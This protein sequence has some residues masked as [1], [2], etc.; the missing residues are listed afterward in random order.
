M[1][2]FGR[3][4]IKQPR[5]KAEPTNKKNY[6]V[7]V[8]EGRERIKVCD[9]QLH[10]HNYISTCIINDAGSINRVGIGVGETWVEVGVGES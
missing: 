5:Y 4:F 1:R 7:Q 3:I 6:K 2:F 10:L 8:R 9:F